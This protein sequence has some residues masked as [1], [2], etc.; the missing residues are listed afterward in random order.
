MNNLRLIITVIALV[1][2]VTHL[3]NIEMALVLIALLMT[4]RHRLNG[5]DMEAIVKAV[6]GEIFA[7]D[8]KVYN[9]PDDLFTVTRWSR[10]A[11]DQRINEKIDLLSQNNSLQGTISE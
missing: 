6:N 8:L 9:D 1:L 2:C 4:A 11:I 3:L 5:K 10:H 7:K